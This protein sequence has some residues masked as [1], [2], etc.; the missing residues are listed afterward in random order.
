MEQQVEHNPRDVRDDPSC[1]S[2]QTGTSVS[3]TPMT[4]QA[5]LHLPNRSLIARKFWHG[6]SIDKSLQTATDQPETKTIVLSTACRTDETS[7][8]QDLDII[9]ADTQDNQ[10]RDQAVDIN[11][12]YSM[13]TLDSIDKP[14]D[15]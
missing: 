3:A 11:V 7:D 13:D 14:F 6:A 2:G 4:T 10:L 8:D 5:L 15:C 1:E 12:V 9:L